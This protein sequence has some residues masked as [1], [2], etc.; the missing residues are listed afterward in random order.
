MDLKPVEAILAEIGKAVRLFR[1]YPPSHPS[2]QRVMLDLGAVLPALARTGTIE[3]RVGPRGFA[4]GT[5]ALAPRSEPLRDLAV[6]LYAQGHRTLVIDPGATAEEVAALVRA[7]LGVSV[8]VGRQ[9]GVVPKLPPLPHIRLGVAFSAKP[10]AEAA[11]KAAVA[12]A[13]GFHVRSTGVFRPDALPLD[14]ETRR[15]IEQLRDTPSEFLLSSVGRLESL[16]AQAVAARDFATLTEALGALAGLAAD[17]SDA[18][19]RQASADAIAALAVPAAVQ[20]LVAY[21]ATPDL[22]PEER[23]RA[24]VAAAALRDVALAPLLDAFLASAD[25]DVREACAAVVARGG[26]RVVPLL[27][28]RLA[29]ARREAKIGIAALLGATGSA[30]ALPLLLSLVPQPDAAVRAAAVTALGRVGGSDAG[31]AVLAALRDADDAVRAAAAQSAGAMGERSAGPVLLARLHDEPE[32]EVVCALAAA[33]GALRESKAV[34]KLAELASPVSGVFQRR[35]AA[36]RLA[37]VRALAALAT[38]EALG[39]LGRYRDD[40]VP[41]I[42]AAA[43][44]TLG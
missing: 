30:H 31:R 16:G 36:V 11:E 26:D 34:A 27:A 39:A 37:A 2:A 41:E 19:V 1:Y 32:P 5:A 8:V 20:G 25:A 21:L 24:I 7:L 23:E 9:L 43:L 4:I 28:R 3:A 38:P 40:A 15:V 22:T 14:I 6:A 17:A 18:M 10:A 29:D 13:T 12:D 42:R 33:L 44:Q 35:A